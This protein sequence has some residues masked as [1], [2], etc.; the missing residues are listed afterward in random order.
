MRTAVL[1]VE[2]KLSKILG[3]QDG[4]LV[5]RASERNEV[6]AQISARAAKVQRWDEE[7]A[8]ELMQLR[9]DVKEVFDKG[10]NPGDELMEQMW[11]LDPKSKDVVEKLTRQYSEVVTPNDFAVIGKLMSEHMEAQV[12]ILGDFTRFFGRLAQDYLTTAKASNSSFDWGTIAKQTLLGSYKSGKRLHPRVAELLGVSS[13]VA[14][15][16]SL[17]QRIPGYKPNSTI[18]EL[19]YGVRDSKEFRTGKKFKLEAKAG[20]MKVEL[21]SFSV[22][23]PNKLPKN[24][25]NIPW[26]NLDGGV[27]EQHYTQKFE[28]KL[29]YKDADGNWITNIIQV[30]QKTDP[31]WWEELMNED[32]KINKIVD[33]T[34]ART[35]YA[36]NG[37]HSNDATLVKNFHLW[38]KKAKVG[39]STIHDKNCCG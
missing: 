3:K 25:T 9:A 17:L 11:F 19:L 15:S 28:E 34:G 31:T 12:P 16:E 8:K 24:Y 38:G 37:N 30:D 10:L 6:L 5:V 13:R 20:D 14:P 26:V 7:A 2:N 23:N 36:V 29:S 4:V 39:T 1:N 32:N 35:A 27:L 21:A 22:L 33:V 18:A